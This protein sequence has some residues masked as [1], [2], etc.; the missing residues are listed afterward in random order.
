[1]SKLTDPIAENQ[2]EAVIAALR[3]GDADAKLRDEATAALL[4]SFQRIA[5]ELETIKSNLWTPEALAATIDKRHSILC[6]AC[7][8]HQQYATHLKT[9]LEQKKKTPHWWEI[10]FSESVRSFILILILIWTLIVATQGQEN[11]KA[12]LDMA[13]QTLHMK[14]LNQ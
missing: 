3:R 7:P 14:G 11:A 8:V 6:Q 10:L 1:M 12:V 13:Q 4:A 2:T 9:D 5:E